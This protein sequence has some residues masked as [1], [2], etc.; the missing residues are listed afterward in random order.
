MNCG[1]LLSLGELFTEAVFRR[2][3]AT[4]GR[5]KEPYQ[6]TA[7]PPT[8]VRPTQKRPT[9][10]GRSGVVP[11]VERGCVQSDRDVTYVGTVRRVAVLER[12]CTALRKGLQ[13]LDGSLR[14]S[15][16]ARRKWGQGGLHRP[17]DPLHDLEG[18]LAH[19]DL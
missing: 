1:Y 16:G 7:H 8:F 5:R 3:G 4:A 14:D 17:E 18:I 10:G 6:R 13:H 12:V 15:D 19:E 11:R 9:L 2:S